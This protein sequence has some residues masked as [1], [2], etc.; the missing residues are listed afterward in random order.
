MSQ[1]SLTTLLR[2]GPSRARLAV[3]VAVLTAALA[4]ASASASITLLKPNATDPATFVG[5]GGYSADG[6]GQNT[7][8]GVVSADV[9]A[10]STVRQAYLY[11][12][13]SFTTDP[14]LTQRTIDVDGT[15]V[16]LTK[17]SDLNAFLST[18]RADVTSQ[19]A[20]KVGTG[21]A[22]TD[23][24]VNSDPS[25]LDGVAL[26][27]IYSNPVSPLTTIAVLDGSASQTGDSA[28]F[29]FAA[30]L[31][32]TT[33]GFSATMTLG[34]GF[35]FQGFAPG[36]DCG[37]EFAQASIVDINGQRLTS[38]AGHYD[39]GLADNGALITVGGAGDD[40]L[41]PFDPFQSPADAALPRVQDDERYDINPFLAQGDTGVT[42]ASSNPSQDDNLFLS[43]IAITARASVSRENCTN[44][45]DDDGDGLIDRADPDCAPPATENCTN[46]IDD[47]GDG[48]IDSA[49]PDCPS[50]GLK[51][52]G[53]GGSVRTAK[54]KDLSHGFMLHCDAS[55][56]GLV[57]RLQVNWG[58]AKFHLTALTSAA[59]SDDPAISEGNPTAGFDTLRGSGTGRYNGV[60][61]ATA[62]WTLTDA[63]EP[64]G[65]DRVQIVI[66]D[67]D[68][69]VVLD[70]TGAL[71]SGNNQALPA[72]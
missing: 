8:G 13:Y 10:G 33:A 25:G 24:A 9:P 14:D 59:C 20:A 47:D 61:G 62:S 15:S 67:K 28:S 70:T 3:A 40:I 66:R 35:S 29:N 48:L 72:G 42:I 34:S 38:C 32:K 63:G 37:T 18:A 21:G 41:N 51:R 49:D 71:A 4:P 52:M 60:D 31:D 64:G 69:A 27:V 1:L 54:V 53:G 11:G 68:G 5:N 43:V 23:F 65:N 55:R 46:G 2:S 39:D 17:I 50:D 6:L 16:V 44:G 57:N 56:P 36:H 45:I 26:V 22:I 12:T 7:T 19:V 30:P 58:K